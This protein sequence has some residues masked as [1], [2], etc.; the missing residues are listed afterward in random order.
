MRRPL[1]VSLWKPVRVNTDPDRQVLTQNCIL[2][3]Y[4]PTQSKQ[5]TD[6]L[7]LEANEVKYTQIFV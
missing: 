1:T 4:E 5:P 2:S 6:C 7:S 3:W